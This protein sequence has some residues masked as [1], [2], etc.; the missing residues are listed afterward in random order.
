MFNH[1]QLLCRS[2]AATFTVVSFL[3]CSNSG[4]IPFP[5]KE[6][7]YATPVT[8]PLKFSG[9]KKLSW[10]TASHGAVK[11][12][13]KKLDLDALPSTAYDTL[14]YKA[15]TGMPQQTVVDAGQL[16][17]IDFNFDSLPS[18]SLQ[19]KTFLLPPPVAAKGQAPA[20]QKAN[21][22]S[23][24]ELGVPQGLPA[25]FIVAL[26]KDKKGLLWISSAE[27]LFRYDGEHVQTIVPGPIAAPAVG[28][29]EDNDGNIW[30]ISFDRIGVVN[31][32][33]GTVSYTMEFKTP[34]NNLCRIIKDKDGRIWICKT[35]AGT[36]LV[37]DPAT[38]TFKALDKSKGLTDGQ[39]TDIAEDADKNIWIISN[40]SGAS[41]INPA[42]NNIKYL[43]TING[44]GNDSLRAITKDKAGRIWIATSGGGI[45]AVD[46]KR[47]TILRYQGS[48]GFKQAFTTNISCDDKGRIWMG[49]NQGADILDPATNRIRFIDQSR[50]LRNDWVSSCTLDD[51]NRMWVS[52]IGGLSMIEQN[53]ETVHPFKENIT[54][55]I[56]DAAGNLWVATQKGLFIINFQ[57]KIVW[58]L[59]AA[60]GLTNDFVQS[61]TNTN[62]KITVATNSGYNIID[63]IGKTMETATKREGLLSDAIYN[64]FKDKAG[65][66]W[67]V[68]PANGV[69]LIDSAKKIIRHL[70][71]AGGLSDNNI[72]D[73]KQDD[74]GLM[75]L[76]TNRTGVDIIDPAAG[77]VKY[78][79]NQPGLR[80]TCNRVLLKDKQGRMWI[81]TDK[82]VYIA[83]L[84]QGTLT[85]ITTKEG[86]TD[87]RVLS[88]LQ[89]NGT[90][91]V[92]TS[93][94]ITLIT[95]PAGNDTAW[96]IAPLD[97]SETLLKQQNSWAS[98]LITS[99]GQY[100]WGDAD[101]TVI[102]DL[103]P[104]TD[105]AV[106]YITGISVM[107]KP[108]YFI[109]ETE[110]TGTDTLGAADTFYV[111]GKKPLTAGYTG[112]GKLLW[113]SV[114]GPYNMPVNL[115]L[116][117]N[118]NYMQFNFAQAHLGRQDNTLYTYVLEGIDKNWSIPNANAYTENYLN[119]PPGSYTFK[120]CSKALNGRWGLPSVFNFTIA[121]PWYRT[122]WAY[123]LYALLGIG[124][125]RIYIVYR[126]RQLQRENKI[127][128]EKVTLRTKQLQ[129]SIENLKSTQ[130]QL[131]QSE[132]MASLGELTAGIAHEIQNPLNFV[133]NFSEVS[134][135]LADELKAAIT[136]LQMDTEKKKDLES[137]ADDLV[138][139]QQKINFH[140]KRADGIVKGM[141]QHSRSSNGKKE[142]TDINVLA[143]EYLRLSY[144]GLRAKD[145]TFNA[146]MQT[147]FDAGIP[148]INIV[149]QDVGRVILN[150][151]TNA[152]YSV[153]E[154]K[155]LNIPGYE[156]MVSVSTK[157]I[158]TQQGMP[159][160]EVKVKDNGMGV[161]QKVLDKIFQPFFTTKPVGQGTGL[162]LSLSYDIIKAHNGDLKVETTENEGAGFI[163][164]LPI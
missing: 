66:V 118:Q 132:K 110:L 81:G 158:L 160:I 57:K 148:K 14:G 143:D 28:M 106:T 120:V 116:P 137:L 139:N 107:T 10:D 62:G 51:H 48:M 115:Q 83:D 74:N 122:W 128:E 97:K 149:S 92:G 103:K 144:H 152:F 101:L 38:Q 63:P 25:K 45:D 11:P 37:I 141:L 54:S 19:L 24:F 76:A 89:Y 146:G 53:A 78:L 119:L 85:T 147:D 59:D 39:L 156:A 4:Q 94:K 49:K 155:K 133:N 8:V 84:K 43:S 87:N 26:L 20:L 138:Q 70:D 58:R 99:K 95:P 129:E 17:G 123:T 104:A 100:L 134:I 126:S 91:A 80:D 2:A 114:S 105:S 142:P 42:K 102:N 56:E 23:L 75:W 34:P 153:T 127:L 93:S 30:F 31:V 163:I 47:G 71:V 161:P 112:D 52:T 64:T 86:L 12:V 109:N 69:D 32:K 117:H 3:S 135:E 5:E 65:N 108:R 50:G 125:L 67:L 29:A 27:G 73:F 77:T 159:A 98:D 157:K 6:M 124:L 82:G 150:L 33:K 18:K 88:L 162:G 136:G 41:I 121:P 35:T 164:Q 22:L 145:K 16:A 140:G 113:D 90:I 44:L 151:I 60:H 79:N 61:F 72:Q 36:V 7:G 96:K 130:S 55:L 15:L 111:K 13:I 46:L 9:Q 131:V 1:Q 154:K 68:G 40:T 21:A